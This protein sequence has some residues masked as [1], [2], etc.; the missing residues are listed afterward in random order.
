M[1]TIMARGHEALKLLNYRDKGKVCKNQ[2][3]ACKSPTDTVWDQVENSIR[4]V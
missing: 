2:E 3:V 1:V 4:V